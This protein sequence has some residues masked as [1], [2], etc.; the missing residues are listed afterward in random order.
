[1]IKRSKP[2]GQLPHII[3]KSFRLETF[4]DIDRIKHYIEKCGIIVTLF[5]LSFTNKFEGY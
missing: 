4:G 5:K 2:K 1:M 3:G